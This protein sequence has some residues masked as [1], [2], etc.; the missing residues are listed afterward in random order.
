[1][2]ISNILF[3]YLTILFRFGTEILKTLALA[4]FFIRP[5]CLPEFTHRRDKN[6]SLVLHRAKMLTKTASRAFVFDDMRNRNRVT[7]F[8]FERHRVKGA[9]FVTDKTL[10]LMLPGQAIL[11]G[12]HS[13]AYLGPY[14]FTLRQASNG[15]CR[16]HLPAASALRIAGA[17]PHDKP[18]T[19]K[20]H[21]PGFKPKRLKRIGRASGHAFT[22]ANA[23]G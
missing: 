14:P 6:S 23:F 2:L 5:F 10:F 13:R 9:D 3:F 16:T 12:N 17:S 22:A 18:W 21:D 15:F 19:E 20:P 4:L 7:W 1:M 11:A 8:M